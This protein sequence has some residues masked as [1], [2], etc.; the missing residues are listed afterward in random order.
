MGDSFT[1]Q[2][3]QRTVSKYWRETK[4]YTKTQ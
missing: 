3:T 1:V 2:K 4:I